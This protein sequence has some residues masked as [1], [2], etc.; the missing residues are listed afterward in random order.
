M[1]RIGK[2]IDRKQISGCQMNDVY[3]CVCVVGGGCWE[4]VTAEYILEG[5]VSV[6]EQIVVMVT[7]I[8]GYTKNH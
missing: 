3:V 5:D 1:S 7:Q 8:C 4:T 2:P 6:L